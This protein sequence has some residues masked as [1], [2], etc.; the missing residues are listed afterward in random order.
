[1]KSKIFALIG[2]FLSLSLQAQTRQFTSNQAVWL[3]YS[4]D[5]KFADKW[6]VHLEAQLRRAE[7]MSIPQQDLVRAAI[8]Y[9]ISNE[10]F[11]SAGYAFAYTHPYGEFSPKIDFPESRLYEQLQMNQKY[12]SFEAVSRFRLEQ[13]WVDNPV[14]NQGTYVVGD[15]VYSNR[16][17]FYEKLSLPFVGKSI[18][19]KSYYAFIS[20]EFFIN[21]GK[22]VK[23]NVLDQ[24]R[25]M[26]G[27]GYKIPKIGK[28]EM[29]YL[30]QRVFR[31][32]GVKTE[33]NST[34]S[35]SLNSNISFYK[36]K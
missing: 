21:F 36:K 28:L 30:I 10:V 33:N 27:L 18:Q 22:N 16:F 14:L 35:I 29:G 24:N 19:D 15:P 5:H 34:L 25:L 6:G 4:G 12:G 3:A 17:R 32:D 26:L 31:S 20:N 8:N 2:F 9:H 11:V 23:Y 13:R 1:M 7:F